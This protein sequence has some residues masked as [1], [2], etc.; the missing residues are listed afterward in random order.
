M[1][2][3]PDQP[4]NFDGIET[5]YSDESRKEKLQQLSEALPQLINFMIKENVYTESIAYLEQNLMQVNETLDRSFNVQD[6]HKIYNSL[7]PFI[8]NYR[9]YMPP[10]IKKDGYWQEPPWFK[11]LEELH[12][13]V[14]GLAGQLVIRGEY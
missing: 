10:L 3:T 14:F 6:L 9:E 1:K 13:K 12:D 5:I 8:K 11:E 2:K 7:Q 4:D